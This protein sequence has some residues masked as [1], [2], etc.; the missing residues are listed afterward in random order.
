VVV[1]RPSLLSKQTCAK[2]ALTTQLQTVREK[3]IQ[4]VVSVLSAYRK[5]CATDKSNNSQLFL[6]E[7]LKVI[8]AYVASLLRSEVL[9]PAREVPVD[10]RVALFDIVRRQS[11]SQ[12]SAYLYPRLIDLVNASKD[13]HAHLLGAI[14]CSMARLRSD[15]IY[16]AENGVDLCVWVGRSVDAETMMAV[17]GVPDASMVDVSQPVPVLQNPTSI[18]VRHVMSRMHMER[19]VPMRVRVCREKDMSEAAFL[20]MM[21]EDAAPGC[22]SYVDFMC[23][24][25]RSVLASLT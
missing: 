16:L 20:H 7:S 22:Q 18:G 8:C 12:S 15:C 24:I 5:Y 6:P 19:G 2:D 1:L 9:L 11:V 21:V 10:W 3:I 4:R 14:R 23:Q 13:P 17:F 25:H